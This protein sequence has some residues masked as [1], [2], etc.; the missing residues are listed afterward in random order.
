[1]QKCN[2]TIAHGTWHCS[3]I[4]EFQCLEKQSIEMVFIF[5][6]S[7]TMLVST[8]DMNEIHTTKITTKIET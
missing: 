2:N 4:L 3:I 8:I 5:N 7:D 1:M 6:T